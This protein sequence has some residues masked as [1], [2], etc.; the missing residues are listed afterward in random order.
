MKSK[1]TVLVLLSAV[2][3]GLAPFFSKVAMGEGFNTY[4]LLFL[5]TS[6]CLPILALLA[7][8]RKESLKISAKGLQMAVILSA[9]Y[10]STLALLISSYS[11]IPTGLA[12]SFHFGYPAFTVV[13]AFLLYRHRPR[14]LHIICIVLSL[15]GIYLMQGTSGGLNMLGVTIAVLSGLTHAA[16]MMQVQHPELMKIPALVLNFYT[17]L[18]A[19]LLIAS[20]LPFQKGLALPPS[21]KGWG[22]VLGM[23]FIVAIA[24]VMLLQ[25]GLRYISAPRASILSTLEPVTSIIVGVLIFSERLTFQSVIGLI[26]VLG[27]VVIL[28]LSKE[29]RPP[30]EGS[31]LPQEKS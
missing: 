5:R 24:A 21:A 23:T 15:L 28:S 1:G 26:L 18:F 16:Y 31:H 9:F 25:T 30:I 3:Y 14:M 29:K 12:T 8:M 22:A 13:L 6:L 7:T 2:C 17:H 20:A 27:S 4:S 10:A 19:F 11:L